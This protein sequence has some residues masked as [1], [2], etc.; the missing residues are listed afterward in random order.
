MQ[1]IE[2]NEKGEVRKQRIL[3]ELG[4]LLANAPLNSIDAKSRDAFNVKFN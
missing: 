1:V 3:T 4:N 2:E